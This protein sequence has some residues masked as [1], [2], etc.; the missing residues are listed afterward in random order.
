[1]ILCNYVNIMRRI[2]FRSHLD[3]IIYLPE[4][5][6]TPTDTLYIKNAP[7]KEICSILNN[8]ELEQENRRIKNEV[9]VKSIKGDK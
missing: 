4:E 8:A 6:I 2:Y 1:M 5:Y 3:L 7:Y 9:C